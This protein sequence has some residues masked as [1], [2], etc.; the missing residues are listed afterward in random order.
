M[1]WTRRIGS[2]WAIGERRGRKAR[3][4]VR[5]RDRIIRATLQDTGQSARRYWERRTMGAQA[6]VSKK[7]TINRLLA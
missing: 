3:Y 7:P 5:K 2:V 1:D 6:R 4:S